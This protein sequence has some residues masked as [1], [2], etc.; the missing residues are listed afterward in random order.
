MKELS[1]LIDPENHDWCPKS[2]EDKTPANIAVFTIEKWVGIIFLELDYH[3]INFISVRH[4]KGIKIL[5]D[6]YGDTEDI[7]LNLIAKYD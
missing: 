7:I 2:D 6:T 4:K 1:L 5:K 3:G